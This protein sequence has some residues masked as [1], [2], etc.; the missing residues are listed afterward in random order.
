MR[1]VVGFFRGAASVFRGLGVLRRRPGLADPEE[2]T[3]ARLIDAAHALM[4]AYQEDGIRGAEA[5]MR[6]TRLNSDTRFH[7]FLQALANAIPRTKQKGRFV[8][9]EAAALDGLAVLFPDLQLPDEPEIELEPSQGA[10]DF[11]GGSDDSTPLDEDTDED[12]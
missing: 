8:R 6:R 5:F 2:T 10:L 3:F 12:K 9:P 1:N 4:V 11:S 7:A